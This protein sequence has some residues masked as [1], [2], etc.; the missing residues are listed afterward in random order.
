MR[1]GERLVPRPLVGAQSRGRDQMGGSPSR[2]WAS[3]HSG[4]LV[5]T[6]HQPFGLT[7]CCMG[8]PREPRERHTA[9]LCWSGAVGRGFLSPDPLLFPHRSEI[10]Q[11]E[12]IWVIGSL[13]G[14]RVGPLVC[15]LTR[16]EGQVTGPL[17]AF[18]H[19]GIQV[20]EKTP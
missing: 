4:S 5:H 2:E 17:S 16:S 6:R 11:S 1:G 19:R 18:W 3:D 15:K 13:D 14:R 10:R 8:H 9:S 20:L 12:H 7:H